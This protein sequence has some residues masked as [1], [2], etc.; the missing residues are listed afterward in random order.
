MKTIKLFL[1]L[2]LCSL[3]FISCKKDSDETNDPNVL[4]GDTN[5]DYSQVGQKKS[6]GS[7][8]IGG[9]YVN[10]NGTLEVLKNDNGVTTVKIDADLSKDQSLA[11][12]N[13]WIPKSFKDTSGKISTQVKFKVTTEGVQTYFAGDAPHTLLKYNDNV[14]QVYSITRPDGSTYTRK[15]TEKSDQDVYPYGFYYIK[16]TTVEQTDSRMAGVKK[17]VFK[18]NHKFGI[19]NVAVVADDGSTASAYLY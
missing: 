2:V 8:S 18:A 4:S 1:V 11:F 5:V 3:T 7:V 12:L 16:V 17:V 6:F 13:N 9:K 19:V 10:I 14:G 15:I